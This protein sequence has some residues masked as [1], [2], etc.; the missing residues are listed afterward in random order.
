MDS[1]V[2]HHAKSRLK[3]A[4]FKKLHKEIVK[5]NYGFHYNDNFRPML[6][7]TI[8]IRS[9][10]KIEIKLNKTAKIDVLSAQLETLKVPRNDASHTYIGV[11]TTYEAP[12]LTI[13]RVAVIY[14]ILKEI[15]AE[16]R[17]LSTQ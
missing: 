12:S 1:I 6:I 13:G 16:V 7:R 4:S 8:G 3:S 10:E 9:V 11:A 2:Q 5:K 14:P 15:D 17:S